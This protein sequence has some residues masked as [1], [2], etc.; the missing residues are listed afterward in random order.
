[1]LIEQARAKQELENRKRARAATAL[2]RAQWELGK[3]WK[4]PPTPVVQED[5]IV[6]QL[7]IQEEYNLY[8]YNQRKGRNNTIDPWDFQKR[9]EAHMRSRAVEA[10]VVYVSREQEDDEDFWFPGGY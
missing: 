6:R 5:P 1:M 3:A 4:A 2:V 7:R 9:Q 10:K 8:Q